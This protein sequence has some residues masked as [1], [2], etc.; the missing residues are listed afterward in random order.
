LEAGGIA[1]AAAVL[2]ALVL[3]HQTRQNGRHKREEDA[4]RFRAARITLPLTLSSISEYCDDAAKYLASIAGEPRFLGDERTKPAVPVVPVAAI[5]PLENL[6]LAGTDALSDCLSDVLG[7]VQILASRIGEVAAKADQVPIGETTRLNALRYCVDIGVVSA[8]T[9]A[10]YAY[11]RRRSDA[12]PPPPTW[13]DVR[14]ALTLLSFDKD[15][16]PKIYKIIDG[17]E[18]NHEPVGSMAK[19]Q[20]PATKPKRRHVSIWRW[21]VWIEPCDRGKGDKSG[22]HEADQDAP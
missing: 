9:S 19:L 16:N 12:V 15:Q 2:G 18:A 6:V 17:R 3:N 22:A 11:G 1:I 7:D 14:T 13:E 8:R 21:T 4:R 20:S 5:P 10:L